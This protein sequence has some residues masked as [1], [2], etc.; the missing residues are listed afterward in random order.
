MIQKFKTRYSALKCAK[1]MMGW[2]T[3]EGFVK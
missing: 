3:E 1:G 2:A